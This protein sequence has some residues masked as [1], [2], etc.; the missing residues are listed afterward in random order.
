MPA[1]S[2]IHAGGDRRADRA[3]FDDLVAKLGRVVLLLH[4]WQA[5]VRDGERWTARRTVNRRAARDG[6]GG[7]VDEDDTWAYL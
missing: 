2:W 1:S 3:R 5:W 6:L 4:R 7:G